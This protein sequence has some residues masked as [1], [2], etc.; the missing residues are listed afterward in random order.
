MHTTD[1]R[2]TEENIELLYQVKGATLLSVD[3]V[4]VAPPNRSWGG[5]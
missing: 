5:L 2:F 1:K 4:L 3:A